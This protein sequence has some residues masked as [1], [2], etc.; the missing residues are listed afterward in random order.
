MDEPN[1]IWTLSGRTAFGR[2]QVHVATIVI[3][4]R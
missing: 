4:V 1:V 2:S 3:L